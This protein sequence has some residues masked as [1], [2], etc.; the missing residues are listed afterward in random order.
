MEFYL[1]D[2]VAA[3]FVFGL[4]VVLMLITVVLEA[5]IMLLMKYN[6][7]GKAFLDA[8]LINLVSLTAGFFI[9][10]VNTGSIFV[11]QSALAN[12]FI[13]F[14]ITVIVEFGMLYLLNR[15]TALQKTLITS[16]VIN[17]VTYLL[18]FILFGS[19]F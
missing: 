19:D 3:G 17:V 12:L 2:G 13:L 4:M 6:K 15:K 11:T 5:V 8:F 14:A 9:K 10:F 16:V 18:Y 1:L 7:A